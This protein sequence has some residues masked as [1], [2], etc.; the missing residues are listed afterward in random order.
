MGVLVTFEVLRSK[1]LLNAYGLLFEACFRIGSMI[2][3]GG[4]VLI[5]MLLDENIIPVAQFFQGFALVQA[6][7][8]PIFNISAFLGACAQGAAGV[9][10]A[11]VGLYAP[12][13][14][15]MIGFLPLWT[16]IRNAGTFRAILA[17]LASTAVG[18]VAAACV[19]LWELAIHDSADAIVFAFTGTIVHFF[20]VPIPVGL[21]AGAI[22]GFI[23]SPTAADLGQR[24]FV[25]AYQLGIAAAI[26][27]TNATA[28]PT[29]GG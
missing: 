3:G 15:L 14:M 18:F 4:Y 9:F 13:T 22:L 27:H 29:F 16:D 19:Q 10:V 23:L 17:G 24:I 5:P 12:G 1:S 8:G 26:A 20:A 6:M 25:S 21:L 7:P 2:F 28:P 11:G